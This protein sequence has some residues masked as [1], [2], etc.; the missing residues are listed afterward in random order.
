MQNKIM[1]KIQIEDYHGN[2]LCSFVANDEENI[3]SAFGKFD[4]FDIADV[5]FEDG[6][7]I[8]RVQKVNA[9]GE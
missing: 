7:T 1:I 5:D 8:V 3:I 4:G 9:G 2:D 6:M